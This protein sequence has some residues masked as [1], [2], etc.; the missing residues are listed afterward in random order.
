MELKQVKYQLFG[1]EDSVDIDI[2]F[3]VD[4]LGTIQENLRTAK[5]LAEEFRKIKIVN[6]KVNPNLATMQFGQLTG[7]YKG[8]ID[9]LNNSLFRTYSLHQ[10]NYK[11]LIE[12]TFP[13]DKELKLL[14]AMRKTLSYFT[15][16]EYRSTIKNALRNGLSYQVEFLKSVDLTTLKVNNIIERDMWKVILF[17]IALVLALEEGLELYTKREIIQAFPNLKPIM[18][19]E[20]ISNLETPHLFLSRF[21]KLSENK[22]EKKLIE[23]FEY[24]YLSILKKA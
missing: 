18:N 17:S 5:S 8:T 10:Q 9:E 23:N 3:F 16:T 24:N 4:T 15:R 2:V 14:R 20:K 13:R 1:S 22:I 19:R 11:L 21:L 12:H 7:V 6:K